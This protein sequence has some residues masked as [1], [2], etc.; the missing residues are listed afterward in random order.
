M[1][2][3]VVLSAMVA[4]SAWA[5]KKEHRHHDAHKHGAVKMQFAFDGLRGQMAM[6][7]AAMPF[8]GFESESDEAKKTAA[9]EEAKKKFEGLLSQM[10]VFAAEAKCQFVKN[11]ISFV[12]EKSKKKKV[13]KDHHGG[14]ADIRVE[15][16]I[17]CEKSLKGTTVQFDFTAYPELKDVDIDFLSDNMAK[18]VEVKGGKAQ[19]QLM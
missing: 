3:L 15:S 17:A 18:N 12:F 5:Q 2:C 9:I 7:G 16:Q 19:I 6:S 1:K 10:V 11:N 14:H 4:L 13:K 8:L